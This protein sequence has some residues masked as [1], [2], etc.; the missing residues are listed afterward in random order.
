MK[1]EDIEKEWEKIREYCAHSGYD[2]NIGEF[3]EAVLPKLLELAKA[4]K[5]TYDRQTDYQAKWAMQMILGALNELEGD[6]Q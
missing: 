3:A 5:L 1:I 4:V 2:E 6:D